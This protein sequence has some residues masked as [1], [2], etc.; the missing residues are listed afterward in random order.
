[1][2]NNNLREKKHI[3]IPITNRVL[4]K[5]KT[6]AAQ[7]ENPAQKEEVFLNT[8]AVNTVNQYLQWGEIET[9]LDKSYSEHPVHRIIAPRAD[10]YLPNFEGRLLCCPLKPGENIITLP[11]NIDQVLGYVAVQ[12]QETLDLLRNRKKPHPNP[13][14]GFGREDYN[15]TFPPLTKGGEDYN[16][17]FP[18]LT[19]GG[20]GGVNST[21]ARGLLEAVDLVGF[22]PFQENLPQ[23]MSINDFQE[24]E[25][26]FDYFFRWEE[27]LLVLAE[28]KND[29]VFMEVENML[30]NTD[31]LV[32]IKQLERMVS[33]EEPFLYGTEGADIIA[34]MLD[35][36]E[37][38]STNREGK[39][40]NELVTTREDEFTKSL[41][42]SKRKA[43]EDIAE[44][45]I[46]DLKPIWDE[47]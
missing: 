8:L 19:K 44:K 46:N 12:F 6:Y 15:Q 13:P 43:L 34:N 26:I 37:E 14:R 30:E 35:K 36:K 32:I 1:M 20:G 9:D 31:W 38:S 11:T 24:T 27:E 29:P 42:I 45:L 41:D 18:P 2:M 4:T 21:F 7:L 10:L 23:E 33:E 17:T 16:Q 5:A 22:L 3:P 25:T 40:N 47:G 28:F 39:T